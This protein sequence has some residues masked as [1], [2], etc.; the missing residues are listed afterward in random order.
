MSQNEDKGT[1]LGAIREYN[2]LKARITDKVDLKVSG[3]F[4]ISLKLE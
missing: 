2:K 4:D 3:G 1:S